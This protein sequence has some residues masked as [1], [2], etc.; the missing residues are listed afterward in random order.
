[1]K[2]VEDKI[3]L[4]I[5]INTIITCILLFA[6]AKVLYA[7]EVLNIDNKA[8]QELMQENVP[9]IDVR[10]TT[11]WK[12]T[13]VVDGSHLLMFYDEKGKYD[14]EKWLSDVAEIANKNEP[15][16]LIC[17]SGSRSKQLAKYLT[18][19]EGYEKVYNVKRGIQSWIKKNHHVIQH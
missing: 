5:R 17:H 15:I 2:K 11:E 7:G 14:L 1:M 3:L 4:S 12:E 10:T 9:V 19:V 6:C 8:L 18:K 13:G 16:I